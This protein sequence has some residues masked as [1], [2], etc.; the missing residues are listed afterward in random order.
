MRDVTVVEQVNG[1]CNNCGHNSHCGT[2]LIK[3]VDKENGPIEVCKKCRC[4]KCIW[5]DWG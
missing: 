1:K 2:P 5:P 4:F 3:E